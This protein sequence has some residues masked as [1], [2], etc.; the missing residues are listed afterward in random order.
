MESWTSKCET[1][2]DSERRSPDAFGCA[3][4]S[5]LSLVAAIARAG[6]EGPRPGFG[7]SGPDLSVGRRGFVDNYEGRG[8]LAG[9]QERP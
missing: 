2:G 9:F 1:S 8:K 7:L 3:A 5:R 6:K 4:P